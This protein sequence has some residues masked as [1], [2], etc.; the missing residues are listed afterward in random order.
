M[1]SRRSLIA[2][3]ALG[4]PVLRLAK[5]TPGTFMPAV[6]YD[7]GGKY[8]KSFNEA[9]WQGA[10]RFKADS[11][12]A[13]REFEITSPVQREQALRALCRRGVS[14]IVAIGFN[15]SEAV[16]TVCRE[17]PDAKFTI[18][19][20]IAK[21]PNVQSVVM[22]EEEGSYLVGMLAAMASTGGRIGFIGGIDIPLIRRF[23]AG[24]RAGALSINPA[25]ETVENMVGDTPTAWSDPTRGAELARAQ[26]G[27][28]VD[29]VFAAAGASGL[30]IYQAAK[31]LGKL[32]IGVDSNQNGIHPGTMLTS[33]VKHVDKVV[34]DSFSTARAGTWQP[35]VQ[36]LGLAEGGVDWAL[37]DNN[38]ALI[39]SEMEQ[40]VRAATAEIVAGRIRV[41]DGS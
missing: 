14:I 35:G 17:F 18:A 13:Y 10:E 34:Y 22:R 23:K 24:Y 7:I 41:P 33:M 15:Q 36:S 38:R 25:I 27:R 4:S 9:A 40:S 31:D 32:A 11:G 1:I 26:F 3:I 5:A 21:G 19:D 8:D 30:G 6:T 28:G 39:T 12:I 2:A 20:A 29:V 16:T 37:D